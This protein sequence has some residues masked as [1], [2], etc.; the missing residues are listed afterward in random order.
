MKYLFLIALL[1]PSLAQAAAPL[2]MKGEPTLKN[3]AYQDLQFNEIRFQIKEDLVLLC[4][5]TKFLGDRSG[6]ISRRYTIR[7]NFLYSG[8]EKVGTIKDGEIFTERFY[9]VLGETH[10]QTLIFRWN[11]T[12]KTFLYGLKDTY[13]GGFESEGLM[14]AAPSVRLKQQCGE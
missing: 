6:P 2:Y 3:G 8:R 7:G 12:E 9:D 11:E 10:K 1:L 14:M 13:V 4:G 5:Y